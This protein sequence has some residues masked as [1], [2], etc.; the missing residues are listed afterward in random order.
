MEVHEKIKEIR[1]RK[2]TSQTELAERLNMTKQTYW[3]IETGK[4]EITVKRLLEV[5]NILEVSPL[6][7]LGI[8]TANST[9]ETRVKELE[10]E[11]KALKAELKETREFATMAV[12]MA[13]VLPELIFMLTN[14]KV[15]G[16]MSGIDEFIKLIKEDP[17]AY[18]LL[19]DL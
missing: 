8:E 16:K 18:D 19:K 5:A 1:G 3:A 2:R 10:A 11:N 17:E 14:K 9:D 7:L 15:E 4:T 13:N 6:E 12:K